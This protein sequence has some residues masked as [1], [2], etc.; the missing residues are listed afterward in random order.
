MSYFKNG[1]KL[2]WNTCIYPD[3]TEFLIKESKTT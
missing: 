2:P 3:V 1:V